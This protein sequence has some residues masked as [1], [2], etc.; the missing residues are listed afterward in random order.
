MKVTLSSIDGQKNYIGTN[1]RGE[2]IHLSGEGTGVGPMESVLMAGAACSSIDIDLILRKMKQDLTDIK[3]EVEGTRAVD[4]VPAV[5]L[6]IHLQYTIFGRNLKASK[7]ED[8][9]TK[10]V[11]KYCSVLTMLEKTAEISFGYTIEN[12]D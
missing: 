12:V 1:Q 8:A 6:K 2:S 9:I 7:V 11:K 4:Q 5:F 3:V 10:G